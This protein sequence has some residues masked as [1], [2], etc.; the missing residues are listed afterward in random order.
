MAKSLR[1]KV[2]RKFR[3]IKRKKYNSRVVDA[4]L[5]NGERERRGTA[6]HTRAMRFVL[7]VARPRGRPGR[8]ECWHTDVCGCVG[9][10]R[11]VRVCGSVWVRT[12]R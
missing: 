6:N 5:K 7:W 12:R 11:F 10:G 1:S 3:T 8:C 2:K 9:V 4:L